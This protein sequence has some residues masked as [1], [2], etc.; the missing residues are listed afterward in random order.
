MWISYF[1][2]PKRFLRDFRK[3]ISSENYREMNE[4]LNR[5]TATTA[6]KLPFSNKIVK[7]YNQILVEAFYKTIADVKYEL[8]MALAWGVSAKN[9]LQNNGDFSPN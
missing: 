8:K 7:R 4:K 2:A 3:G 5:E 9:T 1:D 6:G